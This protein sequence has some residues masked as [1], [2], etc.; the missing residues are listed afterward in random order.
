M[1]EL[2]LVPAYGRDYKT[3]AECL[4]EWRA[5]KDFQIATSL[6]PDCGRYI[7]IRDYKQFP[8]KRFKIRY[9]QFADYIVISIADGLPLYDSE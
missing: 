4:V 9:N 6:S 2:T 1:L 5:G 8:G 7:S 3:S